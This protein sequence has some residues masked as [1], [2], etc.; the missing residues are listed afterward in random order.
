VLQDHCRGKDVCW[1]SQA[2]LSHLLGQSIRSIQ[3]H[4]RLLRAAGLVEDVG[5]GVYR[6]VAGHPTPVS[7]DTTRV[8]CDPPRRVSPDPTPVSPDPTPV[9]PDPT[10]V[11]PR[12]RIDAA[13]AASA[14]AEE[15]KTDAQGALE[16]AGFGP[17]EAIR[18]SA[19]QSLALAACELY[20]WK[21]GTRSPPHTRGF[22]VRAIE[23]PGRYDIVRDEKG[24]WHPPREVQRVRQDERARL[25]RQR[26]EA[27]AK[28]L[29]AEETKRSWQHYERRRA[30]WLAAAEAE[31]QAIIAHVR[32]IERRKQPL[33]MQLPDTH[34]ILMLLFLDEF[35][36]R[37]GATT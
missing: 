6:L 25:D 26:A 16:R 24:K 30:R 19:D 27:E 23:D 14:R 9:S 36:R 8:S 12:R 1:P 3:R 10:P 31:R 21:Q 35:E 11:S 28:A 33:I 5:H 32:A 34:T 2:R 20:T 29:D 22:I 4:L 15:E 7:P 13:A 37:H 18:L 17:V